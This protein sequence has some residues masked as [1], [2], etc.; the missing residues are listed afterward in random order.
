MCITLCVYMTPCTWPYDLW[1]VDIGP[2]NV[3][4]F[5]TRCASLMFHGSVGFLFVLIP[6]FN[7]GITLLIPMLFLY[8]CHIMRLTMRS[9]VYANISS[10]IFKWSPALHRWKSI[11]LFSWGSVHAYTHTSCT[12]L[13]MSPDYSWTCLTTIRFWCMADNKK[14]LKKNLDWMLYFCD[15]W[16]KYI[17]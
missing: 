2:V 10:N 3:H 6:T 8:I 13:W 11:F 17:S 7:A 9:F 15:D 16:V 14:P 4:Y 1:A 5:N 12:N